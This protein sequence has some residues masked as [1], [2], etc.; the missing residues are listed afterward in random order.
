MVE[1]VLASKDLSFQY[2]GAPTLSFP[3]MTISKHQ[4]SL[5]LGNSGTGKTTLLHLLSGLSDPHHGTVSLLGQNLFALS[6][7]S[8]DAFRSQNLGFIFQEAH[9]LRNLTVLENI[10]LAQSLAKKRIDK[11]HIVQLL[12]TL[13]LGDKIN[14]L[15]H[16]LSRGQKQR[17]AIARAVINSP[18]LLLADEPTASLDDTNTQLVLDLLFQIADQHGSTL[19]I[20]THDKRIK[21]HFTNAYQL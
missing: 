12:T 3:D 20:A 10:K 11:D 9:L 5:L 16:Q 19:L 13:Q 17:V 8:R 4:H 14:S 6:S 7:S 18:A 1:T 21:D 2:P 15:P